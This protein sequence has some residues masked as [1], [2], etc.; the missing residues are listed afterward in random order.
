MSESHGSGSGMT[1]MKYV[2]FAISA[3]ILTSFFSAPACATT[4]AVKHMNLP[5]ITSYEEARAVFNQTT[6]ELRGKT[7][8][9]KLSCMR[10]I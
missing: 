10:F 2:S 9:M 8:L 7:S 3:I 1:T 5:D 6:A 4:E